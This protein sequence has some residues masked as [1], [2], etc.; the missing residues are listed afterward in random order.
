MGQSPEAQGLKR[1]VTYGRIASRPTS[2]L[3]KD[4][5][6]RSGVASTSESTF[7][8]IYKIA[9]QRLKV[10]RPSHMPAPNFA[11]TRRGGRCSIATEMFTELLMRKLAIGDFGLGFIRD[12]N[13]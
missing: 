5:A 3:M 7:A 12:R 9:E 4:G 1:K 13:Y 10:V 11:G 6:R 2:H 8:I